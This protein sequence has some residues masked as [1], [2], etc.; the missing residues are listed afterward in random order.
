M[1]IPFLNKLTLILFI[2]IFI[3]RTT[4]AQN[5]TAPSMINI[6]SGNFMMGSSRGDKTLKP[7]HPV[8]I[9]PFQMGKYLVTVAEFRKFINDTKY[10]SNT[11]KCPDLID[12]N[13]YS[14]PGKKSNGTWEKNMLSYSDYQ[15]VAC[16]TFQDINAYILW[17]NKKTGRNYRLPT[18]EEWEYSAKANTTSTYFWGNDE[19]KA[20][21]YAN[22]A[23]KSSEYFASKEFGASYVG[24]IGATNK[25]DGEPYGA[26]VGMYS[27]NPFGLYDIIGNVSQVLSSCYNDEGYKTK[28]QYNIK[29]NKCE[30]VTE[31]GGSWHYKP[32][33]LWY[34]ERTKVESEFSSTR[35]GFRLAI[36]GH[37]TKV[38]ESTKKFES[39]LKK[40]QHIRFATRPKIP[41]APENVEL[42]QIKDSIYKISWKS[43]NN[44]NVVGY[45]IYQ[46][47]NSYAHLLGK[48]Y[49]NYYDKLKTV[50]VNR[51]STKV[52]LTKKGNSFRVIAKTNE[53]TSLPS[54]PVVIAKKN[55]T[56]SIPGSIKMENNIAL[57]NVMLGY[58]KAK[59]DIS[60]LYYVRVRSEPYTRKAATIKF[61]IEVSETGWYKF[62]YSGWPWS[63]E[64]G[65]FFM[66]YQNDNLVGEVNY[67]PEIDNRTTDIYKVHLKKG[68]HNLKISFLFE[69]ENLSL[70]SLASLKFT[71]IK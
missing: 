64:K 27:P 62:N 19:S 3:Q 60:E 40:A 13:W 12:Q 65:N 70:W 58:R 9:A 21:L 7:V 28:S 37:S 1:K 34:R 66:L 33:P 17:L 22:F 31:R 32:K 52:V 36:D 45:D 47:N 25:N 5:Y 10:K 59:K 67:D 35:R 68:N 29:S 24:F 55:K 41:N 15:P 2:S 6:P 14:D 61:N 26:I 69:T 16:I 8:S 38:D 53:Q 49:K 11:I 46:S 44:L 57:N 71:K 54:T 42:E 63:R 43:S 30:F 51:N 50:E 39:A 4:V 48:F 20:N 23:D 18:E 56:V